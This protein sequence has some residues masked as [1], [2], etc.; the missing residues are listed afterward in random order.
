MNNQ[1]D[2]KFILL[3][4]IKH[5]EYIYDI[6]LINNILSL[7]IKFNHQICL[8]E[9]NL[10]SL[11]NNSFE[12][13]IDI[14]YDLDIY[15]DL[16]TFIIMLPDLYYNQRLYHLLHN[17]H[18]FI[19]Y[20]I[21]K[22]NNIDNNSDTDSKLE[23]V[24]EY[25]V[26]D[27]DNEF[28]NGLNNGL[29]N[30]SDNG[31]PNNRSIN[32]LSDNDLSDNGLTD[33]CLTDDGLSDNG[34]VNELSNNGL[35]DDC[36][37]DY[38]LSENGLTDD[39]IPENGIENDL[40]ENGIENDLQENGIENNLLENGIEN[41]LL[42]NG[43]ENDLQEN[44][45]E[46]DLQEN[47]I[48]NEYENEL[49]DNIFEN[50][51]QEFYNK[52]TQERKELYLNEDNIIKESLKIIIDESEIKNINFDK[53]KFKDIAIIKMIILEI[54]KIN[55][56]YENI[57]II[58]IEN[59]IF[60][61]QVN[62]NDKD[63]KKIKMVIDMPIKTYPYSPPKIN[64]IEPNMTLDFLYSLETLE[65]FKQINW[66]PVNS[67]EYTIISVQDIIIKSEKY[68][69]QQDINSEY[70]DIEYNILKIWNELNIKNNNIDIRIEYIKLD[71]KKNT[72]L[73]NGIGYGNSLNDIWDINNFLENEKNKDN[74]IINN[75]ENII[76][77]KENI[78]I[79]LIKNLIPIIKYY[80]IDINILE[81]TSKKY[82]YNKIL[83]LLV[84]NIDEIKKLDKE[85][86]ENL[87]ESQQNI[88]DYIK[89][90]N[91]SEY[92]E[93]FNKILNLS[94]YN[95]NIIPK[96]IEY[97]ELQDLQV[98][99]IDFG[100]L[101]YQKQFDNKRI[102]REFINLKKSLPFNYDSSIFLRYDPNNLS[103]FKFL[104][105]GPKDTPYENGCYFFDMDLPVDYPNKCPNVLFLTTGK[106]T[107][108]FNPN[109]YNNGKVCLSLLGTWSGKGGEVWN[110]TSTILQVLVS[111]QSL[112]LTEEPY[113]NEPGYEKYY[114]S[115]VG[116]KSSKMYNYNV[117]KNNYK[118]AMLDVIKNPVE[119]FENVIKKHFQIKKN[120]ILKHIE[121][122]KINDHVT[123]DLIFILNTL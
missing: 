109:L 13:C 12:T 30:G 87:Y 80:L 73:A 53:Y 5:N 119:G 113:Y 11:F 10:N 103:K 121:K 116:I 114:G 49:L 43:I 18:D 82:L 20:Y 52:I 65:Y 90:Y 88:K 122:N 39:D 67:L 120:D 2:E 77:L 79:N 16:S 8:L 78:D 23:S 21:D 47:G 9:I 55:N 94:L 60:K 26:S 112:I 4:Y 108:R 105:I 48:E 58:P 101:N 45:I 46:N 93:M 71:T 44:G 28:D 56:K 66:N 86:I 62:I 51:F 57:E 42:E 115:E 81:M 19:L 102:S 54:K 22:L 17:I 69:L 76:R 92:I 24:S 91:D 72:Y 31:L 110:P 61:L 100:I 37:I 33:N 50:E 27:S 98:D 29:N 84:I 41:N 32:S 99:E 83:D 15:S 97:D 40:Q 1:V 123:N 59:N 68:E 106:G 25:F 118:W 63:K 7:H 74:N 96:T 3:W 70:K 95:K 6:T 36:L 107:V 85:F 35:S 75:I 34:F 117:L 38:G 64:I 14:N 104:I 89:L 111:I